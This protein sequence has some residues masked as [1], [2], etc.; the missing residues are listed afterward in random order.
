MAILSLLTAKDRSTICNSTAGTLG[1]IVGGGVGGGIG[2][3]LFVLIIFISTLLFSWACYTAVK[4]SRLEE[5]KEANKHERELKERELKEKVVNEPVEIADEFLKQI[6]DKEN[7]DAVRIAMIEALAK[8]KLGLTPVH[9]ADETAM[10]TPDTAQEATA[11]A[12]PEPQTSALINNNGSLAVAIPMGQIQ[13]TEHDGDS[14][15]AGPPPPPPTYEQSKSHRVVI[16]REQES[17]EVLRALEAFCL[18]E[19]NAA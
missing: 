7:S 2:C 17:P 15:L 3:A 6:C 8:L 16:I 1:I 5:T 11:N 9:A 13:R 4:H 18:S 10:G 19:I 12:S 14:A